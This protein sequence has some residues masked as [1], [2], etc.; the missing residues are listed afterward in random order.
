MFNKM[1]NDKWQII[2]NF[3]PITKELMY[4]NVAAN[5][6]LPIQVTNTLNRFNIERGLFGARYDIWWKSA[7]IL[8]EK[9][10]R[11]VNCKM[12]QVG[13]TS[14]TTESI[15][16]IAQGINLNPG[17]NII[18]SSY[19]FPANLY[20]WLNLEKKGIEIR[21]LP[22][23][24]EYI[25]PDIL[26]RIVDRNTKLISIIH[27]TFCNGFMADLEEIGRFCSQRN[28]HFV[29]D[30]MQ[31]A[32]AVS[33]DMKKFNIDA[34][35][36]GSFKWL[37]G[38][39]GLG[40]ICLSRKIFEKLE[41]VFTGWAG[42]E[43]RDDF[44]NRKIIFAATARKFELG[45]LN[46]S[47]VVAMN[48][49]LDLINDIGVENITKR[50]FGLR[51]YFIEKVKDIKINNF[52]IN[53]PASNEMLS[54][55]IC[56]DLSDNHALFKRLSEKKI[57]VGKPKSLRIAFSLFNNIEEVDALVEVIKKFEA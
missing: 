13:F 2:R 30:A 36:F 49:A 28:I 6:P 31:S 54:Q 39:D 4:F 43:K 48:T 56:F 32:G 50:V 18:I 9:I 17:E 12:H 45:N 8:R 14:C 40:F 10:A 47:A 57:I 52:S 37:L 15:N 19:E 42:M 38:P 33:L 34:L 1:N 23:S 16:M 44:F 53:L 55:I 3:F 5:A 51:D 21:F 27:V 41:P 25:N 26:K 46:F 35:C 22:E 24:K 7:D 20:P 29:V 11:L